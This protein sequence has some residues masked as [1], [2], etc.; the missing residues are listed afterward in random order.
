MKPL[1]PQA[2]VQVKEQSPVNEAGSEPAEV[3]M[4]RMGRDFS[5]S[6]DSLGGSRPPPSVQAEAIPCDSPPSARDEV[7]GKDSWSDCTIIRQP[8]AGLCPAQPATLYQT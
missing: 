8:S 7:I 1:M 6:W 2:Q 3:Q 5:F 4:C